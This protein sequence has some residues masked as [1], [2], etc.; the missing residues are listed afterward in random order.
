[1]E[2]QLT[3]ELKSCPFCGSDAA[4]KSTSESFL[5]VGCSVLSMLCPNP[6]L[7]IYRDKGKSKFNTTYWNKRGNNA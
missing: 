2:Q 4:I 3:E 1:M 5:I 7:V 6:S